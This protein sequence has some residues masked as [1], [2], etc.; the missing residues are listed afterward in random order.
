ME[1]WRHD[2]ASAPTV[3]PH[4]VTLGTFD[5]VHAGHRGLLRAAA[6]SA[7]VQ[8]LPAAVVTFDPH[9][10][11]V[12]APHRKPR[13]LM[14]LGQRLAAFEA[15]GMDL[16]WVIP[17]SRT[18]SELQPFPFLDGLARSL[19]PA[20]L[21]VG[22]AFAFGRD[23]GGDVGTLLAWGE[24][25]GCLVRAHAL[26]AAD[27]HHLSSTRIRLA[28]DKG[29]VNEAAA[30]LGRPYVLTG[31][32]EEGDRRGRHLGFPTANLRWEQEQLPARGVY[33]TAVRG[34]LLPGLQ[35]GLTNIGEKPTFQGRQLTVE[36]HLPGFHGDL[37][38]ARLELQFLHRLREEQRFDNVDALRTRITA[39]VQ[40]GLDWWNRNRAG[41]VEGL[42][43]A[44]PPL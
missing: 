25:R 40:A 36:T 7:R 28:L 26:R 34:R 22:K 12:V 44:E 18:F 9:P 27:G 37:Y 43:A 33:V 42:P 19:A 8:G 35:P 29:D 5:G 23:R 13:L 17:F 14:T 4:V 24:A 39:D 10:A 11:V 32:V 16:A 31:V 15:C 41:L 2:L 38:G 3:G 21:H 30:L 1:V 20:E 6:A